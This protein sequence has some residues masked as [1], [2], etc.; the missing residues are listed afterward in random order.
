MNPPVTNIRILILNIRSLLKHIDQ[1]KLS[2]L[3]YEKIGISIDII[4]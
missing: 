1:L 4:N 2:L 3:K